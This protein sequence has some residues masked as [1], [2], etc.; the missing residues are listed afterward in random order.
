MNKIVS[1]TK[2][3]LRENEIFNFGKNH[4]TLICMV[5]MLILGMVAGAVLAGCTSFEFLDSLN[6]IFLSDFKERT[7]QSGAEA[8]ASSVVVYFVFSLFMW[9]SGLAI[10]GIVSIPLILCF[11]GLGMGISGGYLY[12]IYG[13]KGIAFYILILIPGIFVSSLA[14]AIFSTEAFKSS[15]KIAKA[16]LPKGQ[17]GNFWL[18]LKSNTKKFGYCL[19]LLC[20]AAFLDMCFITMFA[21]FFD[22]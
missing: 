16:A 8:F 4:K 6:K 5:L 11:R 2:E 1:K 13:L 22:F 10:W 3:F 15:L 17:I 20:F 21:N 19:L 12:L 9:L 7:S 14:F 18:L